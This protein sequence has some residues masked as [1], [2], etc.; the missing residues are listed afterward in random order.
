MTIHDLPTPALLLDIGAFEANIVK[1]ASHAAAAGKQ[2]R[3]HA[4]AHKC[5]EV[6]RRQ[7]AAGAVGVCAATV[8][9]VELMAHAGIPGILLTSPIADRNKMARVA[10][11]ASAAKDTMAVL[12]HP[13][14]AAMYAEAAASAS[15]TLSVLVDL[16]TGDHRTGIP[17]GEPALRLVEAVCK[18]DS[19]RFAGFQAYGVKASHVIG[20]EVRRAF[21][22]NA[23]QGA[24][25]M[26][27]QL[28]AKGIAVE[29]LTGGS[30]GTYRIDTDVP[31]MTELQTGSYAL[32]DAAYARIGG[33]EF[34][35]AL[36]VLATVISANHPD[37]VTVDAGFKA[38][39]TDRPFG[40]DP[41]GMP[42]ARYEWAG[43]EFGCVYLD[44]SPRPVRLGD[45]LRFIPPHCDPT[46]NLY[47]RIYCCSGETVE[48]VWPVMDRY[49]PQ[50]LTSVGPH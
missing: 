27:S 43:D 6:A 39:S 25:E 34:G 2:L 7:I 5:V 33:V 4:K 3:P 49:Q 45:R 36:S 47:D 40:P 9:E 42:G 24:L 8:P 1:M 16:D 31:E 30:T 23:L 15:A 41:L 19:L 37:R 28:R 18:A 35:N 12:D 10:R 20:E 38:F 44:Q 21:T 50:S 14:Q 46:V 13:G 11:I 48:D 22:L 29:I 26:R 32:M 17:P